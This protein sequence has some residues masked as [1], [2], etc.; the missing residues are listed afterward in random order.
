MPASVSK[1]IC[2][3]KARPEAYIPVSDTEYSQQPGT[4][5]TSIP[6]AEATE[7]QSRVRQRL[8]PGD[9]NLSQVVAS[10]PPRRPPSEH[11]GR[12]REYPA[13]AAP[14]L[15]VDVCKQPAFRLLQSSGGPAEAV[16]SR[17]RRHRSL[18][19]RRRSG[20]AKAPRVLA[21]GAVASRPAAEQ[22]E[23]PQVRR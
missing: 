2:L 16:G 7:S 14:R 17:R 13:A 12:R 5:K 8:Y 22:Q 9:F 4:P 20:S 23:V 21:H 18:R 10:G 19:G 3:P 6:Q 1:M 15:G 11:R